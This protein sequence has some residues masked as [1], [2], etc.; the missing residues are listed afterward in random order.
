MALD[1]EQR[2]TLGG[3]GP[4]LL[5][6]ESVASSKIERIEASSDDYLRALHGNGCAP[7]FVD[8]GCGLVM[9]R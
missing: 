2:A 8:D 3:L 5:R 6:T 1:R 4:T 7:V 9:L